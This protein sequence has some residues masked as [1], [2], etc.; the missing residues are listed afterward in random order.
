M[1]IYMD[2]AAT[3]FPKPERVYEEMD[4]YL[5]KLGVNAGRG[6][7]QKALQADRLLFK[8]RRA[9][10]DLFQVDDTSHIVFT[11]NIT[12]ALNLALKGLLK[13]GDHVITSSMEHNAL[14]RPLVSLRKNLGVE[15][16]PIHC[17][18]EGE[19]DFTALEEAV[20][21]NTRLI[22]VTQAS[23]LL[24]T[25]LPLQK[26]VSVAQKYN[27]LTLVDTAQTAGSIPI[28]LK[29]TGIQLLAFTGHKGLFGPPG[30]GGLIIHPQVHI[31]PLLEGGTGGDSSREEMPPHRPDALEAGTLNISGLVGL[32]AGVEFILEEGLETI[33]KKE[34]LLTRRLLE[35]LLQIEGVEIYGVQDP[36]KRVPLVSFNLKGIGSHQVAYLL[37]TGYGIMVRAGLHCTPKA[38]EL[39]GTEKRGAVRVGLSYFNTE[40]EVEA[41]LTALQEMSAWRS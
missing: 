8:T 27:L 31:H 33:R 25:I 10:G 22:A 29:E 21:E 2:N 34:I 17:T 26:I 1:G 19:L 5:R 7:Y 28:H 39:L 12:E 23:N 24:G 14:W 37:D 6:A 4:S 18:Q 38:H 3:T 35:G 15:V 30:T 20:K 40:E 32:G 41:L 11:K 9:L 13:E 16:T 36:E